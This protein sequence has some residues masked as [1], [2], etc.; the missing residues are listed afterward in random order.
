MT[1][2]HRGASFSLPEHTI[3]AYR[4]ALELGTDYI[5]TDLVGTRDG[6]LIAIHNVDLNITTNIDEVYPGRHR[7][8]EIN[9]E[10][11]TGFFAFDFSMEELESVGVR[12]RV[13]GRSTTVS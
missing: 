12:Q 9:G 8:I 4:L 5:E 1:I 10:Q 11:V 3:P 13:D 7:S 6:R 2:A